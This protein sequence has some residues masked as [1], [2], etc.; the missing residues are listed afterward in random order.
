[1][2][3]KEKGDTENAKEEQVKVNRVTEVR[4]TYERMMDVGKREETEKDEKIREKLRKERKE[5][6]SK[7]FD[8]KREMPHTNQLIDHL[9]T[10]KW[11]DGEKDRK[12]GLKLVKSEKQTDTEGKKDR[13]ADRVR[14][15][16]K[17]Q[18]S[19]NIN[20]KKL[21]GLAQKSS[22]TDEI[23][24]I[25]CR[26][27]E[28]KIKLGQKRKYFE[29]SA[30]GEKLRGTKLPPDIEKFKKGKISEENKEQNCKLENVGGPKSPR[31]EEP[32]K[33][34]RTA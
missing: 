18:G 9:L 22:E 3:E 30:Q 12:T 14:L 29:I 20:M 21:E 28:S 8:K 7:K 24:P 13:N 19:V 11:D 31:K 25:W 2:F 16:G 17:V 1:M 4:T 33:T 10:V 6:R 23:Q 32:K 27:T 26:E 5:K 15:G 34:Q